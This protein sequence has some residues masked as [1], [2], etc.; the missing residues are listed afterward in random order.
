MYNERTYLIMKS[1]IVTGANGFI[2]KH[3]CRILIKNNVQVFAVVRNTSGMEEFLTEPN[4]EIIEA[5]ISDYEQQLINYVPKKIDV[6]Y[7]LAWEGS[8]GV[9]LGDYTQQIKNIQYTC[10]TLAIANILE[11]K[12]YIMAGT[13]NELEL[14]QY[15]EAEKVQP[16]KACIYGI[17]KL[18]CE[19]MCKTI[20]N[21]SGIQYNS[22]I[23]G[24][25]FGPGDLSN[26]IHN[27]FISNMLSGT[28]PRLIEGDTLHDWVYV[29]EV[30]SMLMHMG[31]K[32]INMKNYYLGHR[33][34]RRFDEILNEVRDILNPQMHLT[35]GEIRDA[36]MIDYS[37]VDLNAIHDD[38]DYKGEF[39][40]RDCILNTAEWIK[41]IGLK[42]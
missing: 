31:R 3:L 11:C 32:S 10:D 34:L 41:H 33:T 36:F 21:Q 29:E 35:F 14:I 13:I 23:I 22:A 8:S 4:F 27:T 25:C 15:L 24:S 6:F 28:A 42:P 12:K 19:L 18:S 9:I 37:L 39:D 30:A 16:R 1:A 20:S 26:R 40:F 38:T 7:H 2:G 5:S 17:A